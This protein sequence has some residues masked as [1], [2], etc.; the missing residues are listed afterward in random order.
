MRSVSRAAGCSGTASGFQAFDDIGI[1]QTQFFEFPDFQQRRRSGDG[2]DRPLDVLHSIDDLVKAGKQ[3]AVII[4]RAAQDSS[5]GL[6][7][8]LQ[9]A[10]RSRVDASFL[11]A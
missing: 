11:A 7:N 10:C 6:L 5:P 4:C 2:F 3:L 9:Y 1:F 8:Y